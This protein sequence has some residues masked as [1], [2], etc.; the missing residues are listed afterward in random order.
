MKLPRLSVIGLLK[1]QVLNPTVPQRTLRAVAWSD[2][3]FQ[4]AK[5][6]GEVPGPKGVYNLP[7][8][9]PMLH[10]KPFTNH[11]QETVF[12]LFNEM[13]DKYGP[14]VRVNLGD[15]VVLAEDVAD[16]EI[17]MKNEG[18]Y[19]KRNDFPIHKMFCEKTGFQ[20]GVAHLDGIEWQQLRSP[21]NSRMMRKQSAQYYLPAQNEVADELV[22]LIQNGEFKQDN[23]LDLFFKYACESI[24]VVAFNKRLGYLSPDVDKYPEKVQALDDIQTLFRI[25]NTSLG[26]PPFILKNFPLKMTRKYN[27]VAS[28]MVNITQDYYEATMTDIKKRQAEGTLNPEEN[29]FMLSLMTTDKMT[30]GQMGSIALDLFAAGTDSTARN[31]QIML[32]TLARNPDKQQKLYEEVMEVMGPSGP[33]TMESLANMPYLLAS[34]KETF[35]IQHPTASG[36]QRFISNDVILQGYRIPAGTSVVLMNQ[37]TVKNKKYFPDPEVFRPERWMRDEEGLRST[38]IP[39]A[40]LLPFGFGPRQCLGKRFA[41]Q[42]IYLAVTKLIQKFEISLE[43]GHEDIEVFYNPFLATRDPIRFVFTSR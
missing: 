12:K 5:P 17:I 26:I 15:W 32:Y 29:N 19:P 35:R 11:T 9:G 39:T 41:E 42:E 18:K 43:T 10:F 24:T 4:E 27:E 31:L 20:K 34:L 28:R 7:L 14:L 25:L 16:I 22:S 36:T 40:A 6:F 8:I 37:R 2:A 3:D 30:V 1:R 33:M 38:P 21:V 23:I 13:V